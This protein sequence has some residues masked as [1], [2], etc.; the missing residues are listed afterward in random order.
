MHRPTLIQ[1]QR[2]DRDLSLVERVKR[3]QGVIDSPQSR[4]SNHNGRQL[5]SMDEV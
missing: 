4:L 1:D 5:H 3:Q 2:H